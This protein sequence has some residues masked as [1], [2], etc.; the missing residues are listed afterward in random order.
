VCAQ[1]LYT[2]THATNLMAFHNGVCDIVRLAKVRSIQ[3]ITEGRLRFLARRGV[4]RC[5][6]CSEPFN[7]G[8]RIY[9]AGK[10]RHRSKM[11]AAHKSCAERMRLI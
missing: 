11:Y 8:D 4:E 5:K 1:G 9:V 3:T 7:A 10:T 6:Y 2:H